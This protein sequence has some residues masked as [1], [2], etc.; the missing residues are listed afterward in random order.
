MSTAGSLGTETP[1]ATAR[2]QISAAPTTCIPVVT[3]R[4]PICRL[5]S[6]ENTSRVP[7]ARAAPSP[8]RRPRGIGGA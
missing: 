1:V 5:D 2:I 6:A 3:R 7:H 4:L 8:V